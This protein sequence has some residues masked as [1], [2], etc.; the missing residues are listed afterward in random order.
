MK[1]KF[2]YLV[3]I[4][5]LG[6]S[7]TAAYFS[8]WGLAKLFAGASVAVIIMCSILETSKI[9]TT[10]LLHKYWDKLSKM[11]KFY[12]SF[13][14]IILM[15]ITSIGIY[16]FLSSAYK[17]SSNKLEIHKG[18]LSI[19]SSKKSF[20][21]KSITDNEKI[22]ITK[23]KR[24]DQLTNLRNNQETRLDSAKSNRT[25]D[26]ARNDISI[27][28]QE[29]QKL[30]NDIDNLNNKNNILSDSIGRYNIK[31]L[32]LESK[33]DVSAEIGSLSYI[34]DITGLP[35]DSVVNY[36]IL[37]IILIFDPLAIALIIATNKI[38]ELNNEKKENNLII[39]TPD[40]VIDK[41]FEE[42]EKVNLQPPINEESN[43]HFKEFAENSIN[44]KENYED[45]L[46]STEEENKSYNNWFDEQTEGLFKEHFDD[47]IDQEENDSYE[48][49]DVE[50]VKEEQNDAV[51]DTTNDAVKQ[52]EIV[53]TEMEEPIVE[54][55]VVQPEIKQ[56]EQKKIQLEDIAEKK[57][58]RNFSV[59]IPNPA[60][61]KISRY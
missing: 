22:I 16:G 56:E 21:E 58:N 57:I 10:T 41:M 12:L 47:K 4:M 5:A 49:E 28:T 38:F 60:K 13:G 8:I 25:K 55:P 31:A 9:V 45:L 44:K 24:I 15:L 27:A 43:K 32:N 1:N 3:L 2:G 59:D 26:K 30:T 54:E 36:L 19:L 18:E 11:L 20:F 7:G 6:L 46:T 29:I 53:E 40:K 61:T 33:S 51:I 50:L 37:I 52:E 34:S 14:V 39:N 17:Q 35:M 48:S 42:P 23:N